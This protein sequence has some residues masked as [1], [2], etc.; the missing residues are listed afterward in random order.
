MKICQIIIFRKQKKLTK[1]KLIK[2]NL[3]KIK[4][5]EIILIENYINEDQNFKNNQFSNIKIKLNQKL[6]E[7]QEEILKN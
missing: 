4:L 3:M 1:I 2:T 6:P 7:N 5:N